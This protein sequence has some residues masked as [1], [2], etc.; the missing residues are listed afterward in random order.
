MDAHDALH[1]RA[2][3]D[4]VG[5]GA[6]VVDREGVGHAA[7]GGEPAGRGRARPAGNGLL[8]LVARLAQVGV[9]V[10]EAGAD[11][12]ARRVDDGGPGVGIE[13]LADPRDPSLGD[14]QVLDRVHPRRGIE[15]AAISDQEIH[16]ALPPA[17]R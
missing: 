17:R 1:P 6:V 13:G 7:H 11:D 10:D 2:G 4:V 8:V 16:A 5:D 14:Q 15:D 3:Q 9:D 12:L